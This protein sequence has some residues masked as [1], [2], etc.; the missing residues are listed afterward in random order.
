MASDGINETENSF[1]KVLPYLFLKG[2][3][4]FYL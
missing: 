1:V 4:Y 3:E 2:C